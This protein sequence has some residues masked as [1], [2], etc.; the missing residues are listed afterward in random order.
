MKMNDFEKIAVI[1]TLYALSVTIKDRGRDFDAW[2]VEKNMAAE[3]LSSASLI[4]GITYERF[5]SAQSN[6]RLAIQRV[7]ELE[8]QI[9]K[10]ESILEKKDEELEIL[11]S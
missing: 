2:M 5:I 8:F 3:A 10:L 1:S 9:D 6:A 11:K 4:I 7:K